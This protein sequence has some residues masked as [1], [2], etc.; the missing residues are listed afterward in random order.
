MD[1]IETR[2]L[3]KIY[4][5]VRDNTRPLGSRFL[6]PRPD[7]SPSPA[8]IT[9]PLGNVLAVNKVTLSIPAGSVFGLVGPL[10]AGKSTLLRMLATLVAPTSGEATVAGYSIHSDVNRVRRVIGYLPEV[11]GVYADMTC[12]EYMDFFASCYGVPKA[13]RAALSNDLLQ[14]VDLAHRKNDLVDRLSRGMKQRLG[15]ARSLAHDPQIL[16]LDEPTTGLDP[17]ARIEMRELIRE[18]RGMGKTIVLSAH[19]L[20]DLE[21]MCTHVALMAD[22]AVKTVGTLAAIRARLRPHRVIS[23]KFLGEPELAIN[24]CR[25]VHGVIDVQP[26]PSASLAIPKAEATAEG[27]TTLTLPAPLPVP[28]PRP[29][30]ILKELLV[31]FNGDYNDASNL[32]R[33]LMHTGVQVVSFGEEADMLEIVSLPTASLAPTAAADSAPTPESL[34]NAL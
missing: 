15:L 4:G 3:T 18:L 27:D 2:D 30:N 20:A 5:D 12:A 16:L 6:H 7:R 24:V 34:S 28:E 23:I 14:L 10:N 11:F 9:A 8:P 31:S 1:M 29:L 25:N 13:D 22:G 33:S 21:D 19:I 17:R 26:P 32:L